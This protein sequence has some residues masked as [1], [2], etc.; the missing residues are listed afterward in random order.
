MILN[1]K[2][3]PYTTEWVEY[4]DLAPKFK[5]LSI[6]PNPKDAPGYF[7]EYSSP[8][9]KYAN[10]TYQMD[11]WPIAHSL[12]KQYPT[13]SLHLDDPIVVQIR[14]HL[15][16]IM[17]PIR[18]LLIPRVV[19][20]LNERSAEYFHETREKM[21]GKKL[22]QVEK[23]A[24]VSECWEKT[25]GP[26]KEAGDLLRKNGGP[27]FLGETVSYADFILVS[28]LHF[29]KRANEDVYKKLMALDDA[30]PK[31]YEASKQWLEKED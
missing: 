21:F 8:A 27:F 18:A 19:F 11:S 10:G 12:E 31:I 28:M 25:K 24:D 1:Y 16:N 17:G 29:V 30:L 3:I 26:V 4:P 14:D 9:I 5:A 22:E 20:L 23:D 6:P 2:D 13:P 15:P 7:A